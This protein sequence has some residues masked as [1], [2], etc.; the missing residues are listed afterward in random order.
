MAMRTCV[1]VAATLLTSEFAV[2]H[3]CYVHYC[4]FTWLLLQMFSFLAILTVPKVAG[5]VAKNEKGKACEHVA[6]A[7]YIALGVGL[8]TMLVVA[9][10]AQQMVS[11]AIFSISNLLRCD[12][13]LFVLAAQCASII[14]RAIVDMRMQWSALPD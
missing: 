10:N 2:V 14:T 9:C 4:L 1:L 5:F 6:Q 13:S 11:S 8:T 7:L 3:Y 12:P